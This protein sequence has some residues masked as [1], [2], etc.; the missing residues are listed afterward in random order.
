METGDGLDLGADALGEAKAYLRVIGADEDGMLAG[1]LGAAGAHCEA[2]T[3]KVLL[4]RGFAET[5][6]ASG[7]WRRLARGPVLAITGIE[8][9][10]ADGIA[11]ALPSDAYA[12]DIDARGDGWF[13]MSGAS[14]G[15]RV[16]VS[17]QAGLAA[18]WLGLPEPLRHGVVRLAA[19]FYAHRDDAAGGAPP[20]AVTAL[21][22]P[23]RRLGLKL[24]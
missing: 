21:W 19:H 15:T 23:W 5:A 9:V 10:R 11:V 20:A 4:A 6:A 12:I 22:R 2:F 14:G 3:G 17:F 1:L 18:N 8:G 16:R 24:R 7:S 13:R